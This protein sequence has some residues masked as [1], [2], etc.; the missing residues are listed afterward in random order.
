M[1]SGTEWWLPGRVMRQ[2][3]LRRSHMF[4]IYCCITNDPNT[5]QLIGPNLYCLSLCGSGTQEQ[6][7]LV[8]LIQGL[9]GGHIQDVGW[10]HLI[11]RARK[12]ISKLT[13]VVLAGII[14]SSLR[15]SLQ[16]CSLDMVAGFPQG[17]RL[18]WRWRLRHTH[19]HVHACTKTHTAL[20]ACFLFCHNYD[21]MENK[22]KGQ[23]L[24]CYSWGSHILS[25]LWLAFASGFLKM[26]LQSLSVDRGLVC[27]LSLSP[28]QGDSTD[29][30]W[31]F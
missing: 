30:C 12:S 6:C 4:V 29:F 17:E 11:W 2:K 3:T 16:G 25:H 31:P 14:T 23:E 19:I 20:P 21:K 5:L 24:Y 28:E 15:A 1:S 7:G 9:S 13:H 22:T 10:G 18:R 8:V 26:A 27:P